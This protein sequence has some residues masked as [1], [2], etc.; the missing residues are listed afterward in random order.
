[1]PYKDKRVEAEHFRKR[2]SEDM[3]FKRRCNK[4]TLKRKKVQK[5]KA[6]VHLGGKCK[7]CGYNEHP[8]ILVF[9]HLGEK[10]F[11]VSNRLKLSWEKLQCELEK[12]VLLCPNCHALVHINWTNGRPPAW[13]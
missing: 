4:A 8:E 6:I 7:M 11:N 12:C 1:M 9:H 10:Q 3:E 5:M 13:Q 2:Y